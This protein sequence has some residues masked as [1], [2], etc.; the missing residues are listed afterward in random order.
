MAQDERVAIITGAGSGIGR[1]TAIELARRGWRLALAA[2]REAP[3]KETASLCAEASGADPD[4]FLVLTTDVTDAEQCRRLVT[5]TVKRFKRLD[6]LVNNAGVAPLIPVEETDA[7]TLRHVFAVNTL[8]TGYLTTAAWPVFREH[9]GGRIVNLSTMGTD[10]PF[11]GFFAYAA[12]K[13]AVES[14][15]R[16]CA[17]EGREDGV[18][19][20]AVAPGAV[21]TDM[22]RAIADTSAIPRERTLKPEDVAAVIASCLAGERDS[23]NGERIAVPSP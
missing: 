8:G 15:A 2:R 12:A 1:A 23:E 19:T 4:D 6:G 5:T 17:K 20:F 21:E 3:L 7:D 16:S 22:L 18:L 11:V 10:D 13:A 9:G 14:F